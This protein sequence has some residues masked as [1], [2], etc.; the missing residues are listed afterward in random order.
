MRGSGELVVAAGFSSLTG[1]RADNQ[2]F[3]GVHLGTALERARHGAVAAIAD[4]VSGGREGRAAAELAV[5]ALIEGFYAMPGTLGPA[6]AMQAPLAAYNRW[7]H[8]QGRGETMANSATT[9]T[10]IALRGRRAHLVH[11]GDS[12]AWRYSGGRLTCL[13]ADHTRPEPDLNHVLIRALGI[14]PEL[15]LDHSDLELAEHDRLVL[16][17]DGIHAVLSAKRIAAILAESAS[18]EATAEA[19]AE[20]AIAAGGRD[21]ATAVV[22]DIVRLPAPDHD[23][24]LAGLSA[25]PF[26]DPPRPGESIDGFRAERILS[27]G[28][29]AVLLI[30]TDCEDGSRVVLKFPRREILSDRA[31]RLAFAREM[32]LA[33][34][35]SSPFILAAHPVRPDRQSALYGVQPFLE[36]ETMAQRL[37]RGLPSLRTAL[38]TAIKLT[39]GVAALH[40]LEV[41]HRDI[42]PDNA[43]LTADGGLRL[44]D[45][46]VARLPKVE[47]FHA[48]EIP[49]TPGFMAPEQFE[50]NAGDALTDQFALGVTLYRW[51]TGKWPFGEQEAFQRPRFNRPAPPSRHRP[52]IPSWLDDAILTAIQPDRDKRFGDVIELLR[53][54]EGGGTLASGPKRDIPLIERDPVR[55]WQI[56]SALLGAALIASLLLR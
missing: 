26:A 49:G 53:A 17:T 2:D 38:D 30:A 37:E 48:D 24:I 12:R 13:T 39:R 3:G 41:V 47:D 40:R 32:L 45:L 22:L 27:E 54:L 43:I 14:E 29:H 31:L 1:P 16:T 9:F 21:N 23:G 34:R 42:K 11:V 4:G 50:G 20:A 55:F 18:A 8:A 28:R 15:R 36:G 56:V 51:F 35:V 46:G 7:L 44:I 5:R 25:L 6:R 33:Q 52:E 19:L 10:A